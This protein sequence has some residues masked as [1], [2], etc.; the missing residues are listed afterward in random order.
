MPE[1]QPHVPPHGW[2]LSA[3]G[4]RSAKS[5]AR[6]LPANAR[7]ISSNEPKARQTLEPCGDVHACGWFDE[8]R[9]DEPFE[10]DVRSMRMAYLA[11][12]D[13]PGWE[14]RRDV[15]DRFDYGVR[16]IIGLDYDWPWVIASHGMAITLWLTAFAR[17]CDPVRFW[18]EL[19][20]PDVLA[21]NL[22]AHTV[23]RVLSTQVCWRR[24][25]WQT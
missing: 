15:A 25:E 13:H 20:L 3:F 4:Q 1:I 16:Y 24:N 19:R 11:G 9:R 22:R 14:S 7:L 10:R 23:G 8:V 18:S 2:D 17:L 21:V 12:E 5:L 6:V